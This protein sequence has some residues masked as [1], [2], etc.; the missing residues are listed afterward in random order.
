M[1]G[2]PTA[3]IEAKKRDLNLF[4]NFFQV[5]LGSEIIDL[6]TPSITKAFQGYLLYEAK[7]SLNKP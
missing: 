2:S 5:S 6:W 1:L 7:N 4:I 3:T